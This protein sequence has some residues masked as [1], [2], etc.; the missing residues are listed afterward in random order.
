MVT[1]DKRCSVCNGEMFLDHVEVR[2]GKTILF[3]SCVNPGCR[4]HDK[5]YSF[6][7]EEKESQIKTKE[8]A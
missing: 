1:D 6:S 8:Q 2:E 7:G 3:Y 4:E 5:A